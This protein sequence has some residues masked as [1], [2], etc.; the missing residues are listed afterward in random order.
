M[1]KLVE[2]PLDL[3]PS[4]PFR[5]LESLRPEFTLANARA[6]M[7]LAQVAYETRGDEAK[8]RAIGTRWALRALTPIHGRRANQAFAD[9]RGVIAETDRAVFL[10]FAG[11]DPA[12]WENII[13]DLRAVRP[14]TRIHPGFQDAFELASGAVDDAIAK[15]RGK[16]FFIVGHSLGAA[17]AVLATRFARN[18]QAAVTATYLFGCPR[19]GD[20]S[21]SR[22]Y[23]ALA[24]ANSYRLVHG[25]DVVTRIPAI[26]GY[27]HVGRM[28]QCDSGGRFAAE[29]LERAPGGDEPRIVDNAFDVV[30]ENIL[31]LMRLH[32]SLPGPGP[33]GPLLQLLP[34]EIRDHL[35]DGYLRA[36]P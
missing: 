2:L 7:W 15:A 35:P 27:H 13:T 17:L 31:H 22:E 36:L 11:T 1:S 28:V 21:F 23:D 19:V 26:T 30:L 34:V 14:G 8:L 16:G 6:S 33:L 24:G 5:G 32:V 18:K 25:D 10:S 20:A 4:D 12:V 3:Y 9:T 29:N